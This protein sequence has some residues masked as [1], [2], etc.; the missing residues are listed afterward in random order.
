MRALLLSASLL[1]VAFGGIG[2]ANACEHDTACA[3]HACCDGASCKD[4]DC[5]D[6]GCANDAGAAKV[7]LSSIDQAE[8]QLAVSSVMGMKEQRSEGPLTPD[9]MKKLQADTAKLKASINQRGKVDLAAAGA[10]KKSC[11]A[12]G[13][14]CCKKSGLLAKANLYDGQTTMVERG[15]KHSRQ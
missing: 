8:V 5:G 2:A 4:A 15:C 3:E 1:A 9:A 13:G 10:T 7:A 14:D 11:C 6:G 12:G